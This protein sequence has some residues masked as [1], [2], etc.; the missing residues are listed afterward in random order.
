MIWHSRYINIFDNGPQFSGDMFK[1][2]ANEYQFKYQTSISQSNGMAEKTVQNV[3]NVIK[4]AVYDRNDPYLSLLEYDDNYANANVN[5]TR[6][7]NT[8]IYGEKN[9]S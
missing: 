6:V 8:K 9:H 3:K 5:C 2:F 4:K 7:P 1:L